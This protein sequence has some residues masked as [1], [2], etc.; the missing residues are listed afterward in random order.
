MGS[1]VLAHRLHSNLAC[2]TFL[3]QG[4]NLCPLH[5]QANSYPLYHQGNPALILEEKLWGR[6]SETLPR[7]SSWMQI[8][9]LLPV[10]S[11]QEEYG[12]ALGGASCPPARDGWEALASLF[13]F[14]S[15]F[16]TKNLVR[17]SLT[18]ATREAENPTSFIYNWKTQP[19]K[20]LKT[21]MNT[22]SS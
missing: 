9:C 10:C 2:G 14:S 13:A 22:T 21:I 5:C 19:L 6:W 16:K 7:W 11:A 1:V 15:H 18:P 20:G 4:S 8:I 17:R 12:E 3:D